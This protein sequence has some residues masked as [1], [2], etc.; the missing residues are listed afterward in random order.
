MF[1]ERATSD[2]PRN[3]SDPSAYFNLSITPF[4]L[5]IKPEIT[6]AHPLMSPPSS[7]VPLKSVYHRLF[8]EKSL[9]NTQARSS[10]F[11]REFWMGDWQGYQP[12]R[13]Q[14]ITCFV[15]SNVIVVV[16]F[17]LYFWKAYVAY[18]YILH[19]LMFYKVGA[20]IDSITDFLFFRKKW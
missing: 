13:N 20:R 14:N 11:G 3:R 19:L 10:F 7:E 12:F 4:T 17:Q 18:C 6:H 1:E 2:P 8:T 15:F 9:H 16:Y 5:P